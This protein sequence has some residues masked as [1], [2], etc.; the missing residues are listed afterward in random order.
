MDSKRI[1]L[2]NKIKVWAWDFTPLWLEFKIA[3][4]IVRNL[5]LASANEF[6]NFSKTKIFP[7]IIFQKIHMLLMQ[8]MDGISWS[9]W[10]GTKNLSSRFRKFKSFEQAKEFVKNLKLQKYKN[11]W[12]AY[13][14]QESFPNDLPKTQRE[15]IKTRVGYQW[16]IGFGT[17]IVA[18]KD[19]KFKSFI[20][21]KEFVKKL[22]LKKI[23]LDWR[24]YT[25]QSF[26]PHDLPK[27]PAQ[28]YKREGWVSY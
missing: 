26:F 12:L 25:K 16:V 27:N 19:K 13:T 6:R 28:S 11:D 21:A 10:L 23:N 22:N 15:H 17:G 4:R 14:K 9:D 18:N 1:N 7:K 24:E 8:N 2:L 20:D 5:K 3:R